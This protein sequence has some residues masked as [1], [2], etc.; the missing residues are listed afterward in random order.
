MKRK[1]SLILIIS[2]CFLSGLFAGGNKEVP[3]VPPV[4][5]GTQYISPNGDGVQDSATLEFTAKVYVKS[6]QGYIPEYG[7]QIFGEAGK[8]VHEI[9]EKEPSDVNW[10]FAL[11][12][13]YDLFELKKKITWN[14]L[15]K[16]GKQV[17]DGVYKVKLYVIDSSHNRSEVDVDNFVV[18]VVPPDAEITAPPMDLF[19]PN[20]DGVADVYIIQQTGSE[21][22]EW[23]G[24]FYNQTGTA[25][26]SYSWSDSVPGD[27]LW[28]GKNDSGTKVDDGI[29]SYTLKSTDRAGNKSPEYR[30][31]EIVLNARTPAISM[32][33]DNPY[34]SPNGDGIQDQVTVTTRVE[35]NDEVVSWKGSV[36][37]DSLRTLATITSEGGVPETYV[38]TGY[39]A[40]GKRLSEGFYTISYT[41]TYK[42]GFSTTAERRVRLDVTPPSVEIRYDHVF[43][44]NGDGL[45]DFNDVSILPLGRGLLDWPDTGRHRRRSL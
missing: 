19:S 39:S 45:N 9:V 10:F 13:G 29:Y 16:S 27:V 4:S 3:E 12:R 24:A 8:L 1:L 17:A 32:D 5:S 14:G 25:V 6:K 31:E 18:D 11:F 37:S 42:N 28:D 21:E 2:L 35:N 38:L 36:L 44:P 41:V 22:V 33:V 30:V 20:N 7:I 43:S 34:F 26:R 15:D 40:D 23:T